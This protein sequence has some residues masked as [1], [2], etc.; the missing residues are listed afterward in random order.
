MRERSGVQKGRSRACVD[1]KGVT[2]RYK[3]S[4]YNRV[5]EI[6]ECLLTGG[7]KGESH[8]MPLLVNSQLH[9]FSQCDYL[10]Y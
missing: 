3:D 6:W 7:G 5:R 9:C 1:R 8:N 10:P 2:K 4:K